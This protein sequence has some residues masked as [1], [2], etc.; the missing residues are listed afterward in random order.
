MTVPMTAAEVEG[1][2]NDRRVTVMSMNR[3]VLLSH[4][5]SP[6]I[7]FFGIDSNIVAFI[8]NPPNGVDLG[9]F[10]EK[11]LSEVRR[12]LKAPLPHAASYNDLM[13]MSPQERGYIA[14]LDGIGV[15]LID[16]IFYRNSA[17][18]T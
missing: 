15:A 4:Y 16:F 6:D 3:T 8:E 2:V 13:S 18:S 11:H 9:M 10:S 5:L 14:R 1:I 7:P 17:V 12:A